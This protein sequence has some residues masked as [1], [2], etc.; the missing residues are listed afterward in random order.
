MKDIP[1]KEADMPYKVKIEQ[2]TPLWAD[3]QMTTKRGR[4]KFNTEF[5]SSEY[6]KEHDVLKVDSIAYIPKKAPA[7]MVIVP[8]VTEIIGFGWIE[9]QNVEKI[10]VMSPPGEPV[11]L[12]LPGF[13]D[14]TYMITIKKVS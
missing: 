6:N 12:P 4:V 2:G 1:S 9:F 8:D 3:H 10:E 14:G 11:Q 5:V 13:E 7:G